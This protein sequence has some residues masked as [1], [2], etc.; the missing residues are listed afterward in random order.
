MDL[1]K[2][3]LTDVQEIE[4]TIKVVLITMPSKFSE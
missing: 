2:N 1:T 4:I 3:V